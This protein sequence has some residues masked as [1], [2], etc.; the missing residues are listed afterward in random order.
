MT[1]KTCLYLGLVSL[2]AFSTVS[3]SQKVGSTCKDITDCEGGLVCAVG[4]PLGKCASGAGIVGLTNFMLNLAQQDYLLGV[5][6]AQQGPTKVSRALA[7]ILLAAHDTYGLLTGSFEPKVRFTTTSATSLSAQA[8]TKKMRSAISSVRIAQEDVAM[9]AAGLTVAK[10]LF[11]TPAN[12][13]HIGN[14]SA[15]LLTNPKDKVAVAF[16][17]AV[18][19]LWIASR[20]DDGSANPDTGSYTSG[21]YQHQSDPNTGLVESSTINI[22]PTLGS[23]WG[24]VAT[25]VIGNLAR[26]TFLAPPPRANS[27]YRRAFAEVTK[28]GPTSAKD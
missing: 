22:Q 20:Q 13:L 5:T 12:Q 19:N 4:N 21:P 3:Q 11:T 26:S 23:E 28:S 8:K 7:L 2:L 16:G 10:E 27:E 6:P 9:S 15:A 25:F 1:S 17:V 18:G 24:N 14:L